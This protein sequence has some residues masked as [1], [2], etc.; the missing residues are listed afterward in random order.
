VD[1]HLVVTLVSLP[2]TAGNNTIQIG[3]PNAYTPDFD[4]IIVAAA[5]GS[6]LDHGP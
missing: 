5:P 1:L 2:L 6:G 3:D 4:R